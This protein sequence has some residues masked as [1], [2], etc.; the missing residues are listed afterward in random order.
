LA[1]LLSGPT[2]ELIAHIEAEVE[3]VLLPV[4]APRPVITQDDI[5]STIGD[6]LSAVG[7]TIKRL[8]VGIGF[9]TRRWAA[10][11]EEWHRPK[12]A[13]NVKAGTGA[14]VVAYLH[15]PDAE[16]EVAAAARWAAS[17]IQ[18][19]TDDLRKEVE[20]LTWAAYANQTPRDELAKQLVTRIGIARS[21][22]DFIARDQTTKIAANLDRLRA[23]EAGLGSYKW[24]H[25]GKAHPRPEHV[26]REGK[27]FRWDSPPHDGHPGTAPN[28]G[29]RAQAYLDLSE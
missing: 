28:C 6:A 14:D 11:V 15:A 17:L 25:S 23:N 12:F 1:A 2:R 18:G 20:S 7:N 9:S 3:R 22:A 21:R 24:R 13:A 8:V 5:A 19:L 26:A 4:Y 16:D 10:K 29:C 27:I